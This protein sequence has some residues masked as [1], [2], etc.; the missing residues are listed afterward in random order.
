MSPWV[1]LLY[2]PVFGW[3]LL[4]I[5][6]EGGIGFGVRYLYLAYLSAQMLFGPAYFVLVGYPVNVQPA[7]LMSL[8]GVTAFIA[9]A[10][11]A[12]PWLTRVPTAKIAGGWRQFRLCIDLDRHRRL[13]LMVLG[14]GFFCHT[15]VAWA[16]SVA[17]LLAVVSNGML[18]AYTGAYLLV[19]NGLW[20]RDTRRLAWGVGAVTLVVLANLL[21]AGYAAHGA[22]IL[23][24]VLCLSRLH[25]R[26]SMSALFQVGALIVGGLMF[27]TIWMEGRGL[28]RDAINF[29]RPVEERVDALVAA[30]RNEDAFDLFSQRQ[31]ERIQQR[32]DQSWLFTQGILWTPAIQPFADGATLYDAVLALVPRA[33]WPDKPVVAGGRDFIT[34]YT[35]VV[36]HYSIEVSVGLHPIFEFYINYGLPGVL[37]GLFFFGILCGVLDYQFLLRGSSS[38]LVQVAVCQLNWVLLVSNVMAELV[39]SAI[40]TLCLSALVAYGVNDLRKRGVLLRLLNSTQLGGARLTRQ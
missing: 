23:F 27:Y 19:L 18:L 9:G 39:M 24:T 8:A 21:I 38:F 35:G 6:K 30:S 25:D 20:A 11:V 29:D 15:L 17:T 10:Y 3:W 22:M 34:Q 31:A 28:V 33:L 40:P 4:M 2:P 16:R 13:A 12:A 36:F 26:F 14:L 7:A 5:R 32:L 37:G 1:L